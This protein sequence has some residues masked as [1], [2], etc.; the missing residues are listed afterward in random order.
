MHDMMGGGTA[1]MWFWAVFAILLLALL[2]AGVVWLA[3]TLA[4]SSPGGSAGAA[5]RELDLR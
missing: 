3:R 4:G 1:F 2:A 5:R